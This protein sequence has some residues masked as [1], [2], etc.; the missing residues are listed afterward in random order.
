MD[1]FKYDDEN[2]LSMWIQEKTPLNDEDE[3]DETLKGDNA[4]L[5]G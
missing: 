3:D 2:G 1:T 5:E 4:N